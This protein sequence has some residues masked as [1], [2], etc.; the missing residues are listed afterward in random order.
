MKSTTLYFKEGGSDK[1]YRASI[2]ASGEGY[3][4]NYAYGR[5]GAT[6]NTGT[7]TTNPVDHD[8]A[9][10]IYEKLVRE[11]TAKGYTSGEDTPAYNDGSRRVT[12]IRPQLLNPVEDPETLLADD[13]FYLQP[14][15]DG[16]RLLIRKQGSAVT[17][18]NRRGIECGIPESIR[19]AAAV[20]PGDFLLDGEAVGEILHVFDLLEINGTCLQAIPYK[21]RLAELLDLLA[22]GLQEG[23]QWVTTMSGKSA[24]RSV[25]D[26]VRKERGE[27]V[28]FKRIAAPYSAGRPASG[29][30]QYKFKF[31]ETASVI[32]QSVNAKRSIAIA[33]R[34][35]GR[36]VPAGNV[37]IPA[38][39]PVPP[40]GA[41]AEVRYLYAYSESGALYQPVYLG[42]RDDIDA[43]ECTRDQLKFRQEVA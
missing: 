15:H 26:Q 40:D 3:V 37:T 23:I 4:V 7:K 2:E 10:R 18:I 43:T 36:L 42:V 32:V 39:Q 1:V 31:V 20:L 13:A 16:K 6:L 11:K 12:D 19:A 33:V 22:R 35:G 30:D 9:T 27:G 28:V 41:I 21:D 8:A 34:Q 38:N 5:R 25:F 17:G 24:K 29:G 14:K